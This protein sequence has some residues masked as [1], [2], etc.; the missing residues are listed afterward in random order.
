MF[1]GHGYHIEQE[2]PTDVFSEALD[3]DSSSERKWN[4][5]SEDL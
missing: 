2:Y 1:S 5:D 4:S 3:T